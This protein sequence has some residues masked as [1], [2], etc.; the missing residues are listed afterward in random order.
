MWFQIPFKQSQ[1]L[2]AKFQLNDVQPNK[3]RNKPGRAIVDAA[4]KTQNIHGVRCFEEAWLS[5]KILL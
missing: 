1:L 3:A 2:P 5:T 4:P